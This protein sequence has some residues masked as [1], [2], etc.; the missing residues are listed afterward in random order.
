MGWIIGGLIAALVGTAMQSYGQ[1]EANRKAQV[2]MKAAQYALGSAQDKINAQIQEAAAGYESPRRI[3]NQEAEASRI[4][5]D[6]KADVAESQA[7]RDTQQETAGNVS[8]D[9][10]AARTASQDLTKQQFNAFAD[11]IGQIRSAGTLRQNEGFRLNRYAQKVDQLAKNAR[12]DFAVGQAQAQDAL[13][14]KDGLINLGK[15]VQAIGAAASM[16][17]GIAAAGTSAA[18]NTATATG[19]GLT[20]GGTGVGGLNMANAGQVLLDGSSAAANSAW[21]SGGL[22]MAN[23]GQ[24]LLGGSSAAAN[25]WTSGIPYMLGGGYLATTPLG[26]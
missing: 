11:L 2:K 8:E 21:A 18:A 1:A 22:K 12:G 26:D 15:V 23:A 19:T 16:Y 20:A 13:H 4:A 5:S 9:Y 6:I 25:P 24:A 17:G 3:A 10:K 7:I 14:S